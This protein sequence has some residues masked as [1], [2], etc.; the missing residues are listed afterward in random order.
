MA[1]VAGGFA[2]LPPCRSRRAVSVLEIH[3]RADPVVPYGGDADGRG[4]VVPWLASWVAR[5]RCALLRPRSRAIAPRT[6]RY[7]WGACRDGTVVVHVAIAGGRHQWPGASP[8]DA[9]P[10]ATISAA[11]QVWR[12]LAGR[13]LAG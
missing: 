7:D 1:I 12:F 2:T 3:G 8:P 10:A 13:R 6:V 11:A 9:G 4:A 5:D